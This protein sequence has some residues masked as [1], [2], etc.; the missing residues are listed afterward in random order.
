MS[1]P[2][3]V[4]AGQASLP[5]QASNGPS[6]TFATVVGRIG[7]PPSLPKDQDW[8]AFG[9]RMGSSG[10]PSVSEVAIS[11]GGEVRKP[12]LRRYIEGPRG[13]SSDGRAPA[14]QAGGRRFDPGWLHCRKC[15]QIA[16][17]MGRMVFDWYSGLAESTAGEYHIGSSFCGDLGFGGCQAGGCW[18]DTSWVS[19]P[20]STRTTRSGCRGRLRLDAPLE[21]IQ[22]GRLSGHLGASWLAS[23]PGRERAVA[24]SETPARVRTSPGGRARYGAFRPLPRELLGSVWRPAG[25]AAGW[26]R[27]AIEAP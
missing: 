18:F 10:D 16:S 1:R 15:L 13:H 5:Q 24:A 27:S 4:F 23:R 21:R 11:I 19:Q 20:K 17:F 14:L 8:T 3:C 6:D 22:E 25:H 26:R 7:E 9:Q 12:A 2:G